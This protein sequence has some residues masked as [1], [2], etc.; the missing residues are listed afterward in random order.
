VPANLIRDAVLARLAPLPRTRALL[1]AVSGIDGAGKSTLAREVAHRLEAAGARVTLLPLDEWHQPSHVRFGDGGEHFYR[2]AFRWEE[3][4]SR[5]IEPLRERRSLDTVVDLVQF[6]SDAV[7][8]RRFHFESIDVILVEGIFLLR[9][10]LRPRYDLAVWID[11]SFDVALE[12]ALLRNQEGL[13]PVQLCADYHR[14]YF[15]AQRHHLD[16]DDPIGS[17]DLLLR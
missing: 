3:L 4:F 17:A 7:A 15:P 10:E 16:R 9:H 13:S 1:V 5:V 2:H 8:P 6:P 12:R 14:I 11:C